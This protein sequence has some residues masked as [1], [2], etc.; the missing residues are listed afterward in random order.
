MTSVAEKR[1]AFRKLAKELQALL[2]VAEPN[3]V[4]T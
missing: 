3:T 4:T 1:R 2:A